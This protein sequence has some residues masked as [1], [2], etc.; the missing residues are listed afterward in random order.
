MPENDAVVKDKKCFI[1]S[2]IGEA[3]SEARIHGEWFLDGIVYPAFEQFPRY[4]IK[5]SDLIRVPGMIDGQIINHLM[6]DD[7]VIADMTFLNANVF[8]EIGIRHVA[9]KPIIHMFRKDV[10]FRIPFDVNSFR[11]IE[12][13]VHRPSFIRNAKDA[14]IDYIA[15]TEN[16]NFHV[17]NPITRA[18]GSQQLEQNATPAERVLLDRIE[19]L[20][21]RMRKS[22]QLE[23][24]PTAHRRLATYLQS[25]MADA[26]HIEVQIIRNLDESTYRST[27]QD[28]SDLAAS[29]WGNDFQMITGEGALIIALARAPSEKDIHNFGIKA[30]QIHNV[31]SAGTVRPDIFS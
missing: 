26:L 31:I 15:S 11:A 13:E 7:L 22:E 19:A 6:D 21:G 29:I 3:D 9:Q 18:R 14:L 1:V 12:F 25:N 8:Y 23:R 16:P 4:D 27:A 10:N 5:R 28:V 2:A 24:N 20:E 30:I 17:E